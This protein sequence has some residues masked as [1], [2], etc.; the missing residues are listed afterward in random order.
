MTIKTYILDT[1]IISYLY[2]RNAPFH[3]PVAEKL[4]KL[5]DQDKVYISILSLYEF[6]YGLSFAD[7]KIVDELQDLKKSFLEL[8]EVLQL[9]AEGSPIF[10]EI[11]ARYRNETGISAKAIERHNVDFMLAA[12]AVLE[13]AVLVSN[14][15]IF[16]RIQD[17]YPYLLTENWTIA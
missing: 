2:E 8:F 3:S 4:S 1:N 11:K 13:K 16:E 14:D 5:S 12:S 6:E 15:R 7:I 10:G 17:A 9:C